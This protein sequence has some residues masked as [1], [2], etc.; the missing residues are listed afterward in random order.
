[1]VDQGEVHLV[2]VRESYDDLIRGE[3]IP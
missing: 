1:M 2:R 3:V